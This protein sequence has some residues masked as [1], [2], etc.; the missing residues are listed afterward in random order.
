MSSKS[1]VEELVFYGHATLMSSLTKSQTVNKIYSE[2]KASAGDPWENHGKNHRKTI[3]THWKSIGKWRFN[4]ISREKYP[5][6][7]C[8]NNYLTKMPIYSWCT[9]WTWWFCHSLLFVYRR[10]CA[11]IFC[12]VPKVSWKIPSR[13]SN[14]KIRMKFLGWSCDGKSTCFIGTF[15][16]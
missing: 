9:Y 6:V 7:N 14:W 10:I 15:T 11:G 5:L 2:E 8:Q 16:I 4:G 12:L 3:G 1:L 13:A